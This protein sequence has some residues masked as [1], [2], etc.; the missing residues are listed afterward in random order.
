MGKLKKKFW[1]ANMKW[2][3]LLCLLVV[4][5]VTA[6]YL[7]QGTDSDWAME[8][9]RVSAPEEVLET[10]ETTLKNPN[11]QINIPTSINKSQKLTNNETET[12]KKRTQK[13]GKFKN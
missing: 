2:V 13:I 5:L 11:S 8:S 12:T 10:A 6:V 3:V 1:R 9:P 4:A 7:H